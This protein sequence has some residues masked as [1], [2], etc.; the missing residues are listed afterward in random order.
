MNVERT[1]PLSPSITMVALQISAGNC[2]IEIS[3]W[4][5]PFIHRSRQVVPTMFWL[6]FG[7]HCG[8]S[9]SYQL[10]LQ[11]HGRRFNTIRWV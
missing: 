7:P 2:L 6:E 5:E 3:L 10:D 1:C 9:V 11:A 4:Q 8:L